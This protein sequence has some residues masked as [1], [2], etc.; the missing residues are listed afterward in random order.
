MTLV[1]VFVTT[2]LPPC[3]DPQFPSAITTPNVRDSLRLVNI[4]IRR[5]IG[6]VSVRRECRMLNTSEFERITDVLNRAKRDTRV[7]PNVYDAFAFLHANPDVNVGAHQG[8]GFLPFHRV[9]VFLFEKLLRMYDP[10]ISLCYWDSSLEPTL[11]AS[12]PT[13]TSRLFGTPSGVVQSGFAGGWMTPLGPL[14]RNVGQVGRPY[15]AQDLERILQRDFLGEISFPAG[16]VDNNLEEKHNY[17][18]SFVGGLMGQVETASYDPI[19]WFHHTMVDCLYEL[20][21]EQQR[22]KGIN[23]MRDWPADYGEPAHAPF[24]AMRMGRLRMIDGA[25]DFFTNR[26]FRCLPSPIFCTSNADCGAYMRCNPATSRC[27]SDT[28]DVV[29][30]SSGAASDLNTL[31]NGLGGPRSVNNLLNSAPARGFNQLFQAPSLDALSASSF[32]QSIGDSRFGSGT[33]GSSVFSRGRLPP[34]IYFQQA[35]ITSDDILFFLAI[36]PRRLF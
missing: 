23:P 6:P 35:S 32:L 25:N 27:L 26:T 21:R 15:I 31:L 1:A 7:R 14:T 28:L 2:L 17:V 5:P 13:W 29:P 18:H 30:A 19:F 3:V 8:P 20:F 16:D 22:K 10:T 33:L 24:A 34:A 36:F 11:P 9:F 12:S 4:L